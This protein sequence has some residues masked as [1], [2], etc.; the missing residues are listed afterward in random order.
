M[1]LTTAQIQNAYVAFFNR[2]ADVEGLNYWLAYTGNSAELLNT[3]AQS[4]EY[5]SLYSGMNNTQLVNAVY[6]NLFGHAPDIEG[7]NYWVNQLTQGKLAIGNIADAINKGAQGTD[8]TIITNKVAAAGAFTTALDTTAEV[9][10]YASVN[11]TGLAAVKAWLA[12][13]TSDAATVPTTDSINTIIGTV[14]NN[15]AA[16]G[17][18]YTLTKGIDDFNAANSKATSG[19]DTY[20][21]AQD[22]NAEANTYNTGDVINGGEGVD[23]LSLTIASNTAPVTT[24]KA[25]EVIDVRNTVGGA[26]FDLGNTD[27][28]VSSLKNTAST[29]S[30]N[31]NNIASA[32]ATLAIKDVTSTG[33]ATS[34]NYKSGALSGSSDTASLTLNNVG[35]TTNTHTVSLIGGAA[36]E[37][38]EN[39]A[40]NT[41]TAAAKLAALN[42]F[43]SSY[44]TTLKKLTVTGSKDLSIGSKSSGAVDFVAAGGTVDASAFK[45]ALKIN[46]SDSTDIDV[47]GG[48]G[49]DTFWFAGELTATDKVDGG[50]GRD[51]VSANTFTAVVGAAAK[52]SNIEIVDIAT[53]AGATGTL[54]ASKL[55][56]LD[57]ITF[58]SGIAA[59]SATIS[60]FSS[61][62]TVG[63]GA[64]SSG[65]L[66]V[67]VKDAT[68]AANTADALT[69][70]LGTD[71]VS[72]AGGYGTVVA[73][74]VETITIETFG[75]TSAETRSLTLTND[76]FNQNIVVKGAQNLALQANSVAGVKSFDASAAT[77]T[78]TTANISFAT[79]GA[80]IK[81]GSKA[82]TLTGGEGNDVISGGAGD[83]VLTGG[84]GSDV[85]NGGDG[86]DTF[87]L[88]TNGNSTNIAN[89][90][91]D[92]LESLTLSSGGDKIRVNL[93]SAVSLDASKVL[94]S[95]L[96]GALPAAA[97]ADVGLAEIIVLDSSVSALQAGSAKAVQELLFNLAGTGYASREVLV[98]YS[99]SATG[100]ARLAKA[101]F[102]GSGSGFTD[103]YDMAVMKGIT[104][105]AFNTSFDKSNIDYIASA[106]SANT[107]YT[108]V[109]TGNITGTASADTYTFANRLYLDQWNSSNTLTTVGGADTV[110]IGSTGAV[111]IADT[112][113]VTLTKTG[114]LAFQFANTGAGN[115]LTLNAT[116]A[117]AIDSYTGLGGSTDALTLFDTGTY[118]FVGKFASG[119]E[120]I[121]LGANGI[122]NIALAQSTA[123]ALDA[124][125]VT[126]QSNTLTINSATTGTL[127]IT[128]LQANLTATG[129]AAALNIT[130]VDATSNAVTVTAGTGNLSF[131]GG[132]AGDTVT[133][134]GLNSASQ[135]L[136]STAASK[137]DI[138]AGAGAQT[139]TTGTGNDTIVGGAGAD[140][141]TGG[142]G[143]DTFAYGTLT[144][145]SAQTGITLATADTIADF[146][147]GTD[148][149][150][151]GTAGSGTNY[152]EAGAATDFAT[153]QAAA[154]T[155]MDTT[156][157]YYL[158][159]TAADGGLLFVDSNVDGTA[160]AVIKLTGITS[161]NF[162][163]TD[164]IA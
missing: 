24:V 85:L 115:Q 18:T 148:L 21:A 160:D 151:T 19:N 155:A 90:K 99:D 89:G 8:A 156:V 45:G 121:T 152:A 55:A 37:G 139:I 133:V 82:D 147:S 135:T 140:V 81:G 31:F 36:K 144:T 66:T 17:S 13:V 108:D 159:S 50:A 93:S 129:A 4:A 6:Q 44:A 78:V 59:G 54:D 46:V 56:G 126:T 163:F 51:T 131:S 158:T 14:Q 62:G 32:T 1:A 35:S 83:D 71:R 9:V 136:S 149:I 58:S 74:G 69:I 72:D 60:N 112:T 130:L 103:V 70:N 97:T 95:A 64:T 43:D 86:S 125:A 30:L 94:V 7:L 124:T 157:V 96:T 53:T 146:V 11:S 52:L 84:L 134:T 142:T 162:A 120:T 3:F 118:T 28:S 34:F 102:N 119:M 117:A 122:Y 63:I 153:A 116:Q 87:V 20:I 38:F 27:G 113:A 88:T 42:V 40:I 143:A 111:N 15:V 68:L 138:T 105:A 154:D 91:V 150:K 110:V 5:K 107:T 127:N 48:D 141:M 92:T 161:S 26:S 76:A 77:G 98:V 16:S 61:N 114:T 33:L 12:A 29:A 65:T 128:G 23:T 57:T 100:D 164:I 106:E 123:T 47:K 67:Q 39:V 75:P 10:A 132:N 22:S 25:V 73:G 145:V 137:F 41:E 2:P 101:V 104:T 49:N 79:A 80:T 109:P